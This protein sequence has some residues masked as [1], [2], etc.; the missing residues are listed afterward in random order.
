MTSDGLPMNIHVERLRNRVSKD[1]IVHL[2]LYG[3]Y[4]FFIFRDLKM[5]SELK[6]T[7]P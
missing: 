2:I 1:V 3:I 7:L 6:E 4:M 5:V